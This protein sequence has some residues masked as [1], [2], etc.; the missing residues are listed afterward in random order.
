MEKSRDEVKRWEEDW[1]RR[2]GELV[3]EWVRKD[4]ER[5]GTVPPDDVTYTIEIRSMDWST[6]FW[7]PGSTPPDTV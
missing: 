1:Q 3:D 7:T 6:T 5:H 2:L 4:A